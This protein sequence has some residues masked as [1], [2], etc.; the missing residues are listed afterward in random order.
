MAAIDRIMTKPVKPSALRQCLQELMGRRAAQRSTPSAQQA[1]LQGTRV[2]LAEDN[3]VNQKIA[4]R[5]LERLGA[6][7]AVV[8]TG[9]A[10]IDYLSSA[11]VDAV[12]MDCQMPIL[13]GYEA[14]RRIRQGAA[15]REAV[16]LPI[17]AVT[18]HALAGDRERCLAAGMSD[19]LTKPFDPE[20]LRSVLGALIAA[21]ESRLSP[22][23]SEPL[24][25]VAARRP[26]R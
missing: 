1:N 20:A 24:A 11:S 6:T 14:T 15:G 16:D 5:I 10:A 25:D 4:C 21:R 7:V 13:D 26:M 18:A 19:Y 3:E 22:E 2:L 23:T 17:I 9:Q 8:D 12:L